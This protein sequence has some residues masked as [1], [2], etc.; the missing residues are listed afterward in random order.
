MVQPT[1]QLVPTSVAFVPTPCI[2]V[3]SLNV[4]LQRNASKTLP[5]IHCAGEGSGTSRPQPYP[6]PK[7]HALE[8]VGCMAEPAASGHEKLKYLAHAPNECTEGNEHEDQTNGR[9]VDFRVVWVV[10]HGALAVREVHQHN[11]FQV[12][13]ISSLRVITRQMLL[14]LRSHC[15]FRNPQGATI[16]P[17]ADFFPEPN[18][19]HGAASAGA[20]LPHNRSA[21]NPRALL[22]AGTR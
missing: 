13:L 1:V 9:P 16:R 4:R 7:A 11:W 5:V 15:Y 6:A 18:Q 2:S 3:H 10:I 8:S 14:S 19:I 20:S 22:A 21:A 17:E 12:K